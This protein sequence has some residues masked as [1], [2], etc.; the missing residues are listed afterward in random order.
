MATLFVT[1]T[2]V[3][4]M[5]VI[6][7]HPQ[8]VS[9]MIGIN[10]VWRWIAGK[11]ADAVP[12]DEFQATYRRLLNR[13]RSETDARLV[14]VEPFLIESDRSDAFRSRLEPYIQVVDAFAPQYG[15]LLVRTQAAFDGVLPARSSEF[16]SGDRVHPYIQ[17]HAV[18]AR[19]WLRV[20]GY[21]D[22]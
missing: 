10:D 14:L 6:N 21:G 7:Q 2:L 19:A 1:S 22:V 8:W 20:I 16:W 5:D 12:L 9:V 13:V 17:G 4:H 18:I 11:F 3:G 15:A